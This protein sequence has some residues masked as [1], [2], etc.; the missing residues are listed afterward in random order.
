MALQT[1]IW[2]LG[3]SHVCAT[4][5]PLGMFYQASHYYSF[6]ASELDMINVYFFLWIMFMEPYLH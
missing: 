3:Y 1:D 4:M 6:Q 5:A 2:K